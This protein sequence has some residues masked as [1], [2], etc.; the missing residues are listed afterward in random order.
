[1]IALAG[2]A[3]GAA[4]GALTA[5]RHGGRWPDMLQYAAGF[6]TAFG[7]LGMIATVVIARSA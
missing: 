1:M 6:G 7:L 3:L 2:F 4:T 5:R